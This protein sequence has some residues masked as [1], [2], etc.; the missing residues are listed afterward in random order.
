MTLCLQGNEEAKSQIFKVN[1]DEENCPEA[2]FDIVKLLQEVL[3]FR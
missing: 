3:K 2:A 1:D